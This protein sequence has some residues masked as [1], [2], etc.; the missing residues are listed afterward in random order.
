MGAYSMVQGVGN[1]VGFSLLG[2]AYEAISPEA[3][4]MMCT[5]ALAVATSIIVLF[6]GETRKR[7]DE[8]SSPVP[9]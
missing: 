2:W 1:I 6:V 7:P 3:P 5:F 8:A 9:D 4:I